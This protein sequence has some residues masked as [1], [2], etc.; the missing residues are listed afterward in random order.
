MV[1]I[2]S[3]PVAAHRSYLSNGATI[4]KKRHRQDHTGRPNS[5][6]RTA[7]ANTPKSKPKLSLKNV[8]QHLGLKDCW[9]RETEKDR[10][11]RAI[12]SLFSTDDLW[13]IVHDSSILKPTNLWI[14]KLYY[15]YSTVELFSNSLW[16]LNNA[17]QASC[18]NWQFPLQCTKLQR[19]TLEGEGEKT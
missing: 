19:C 5:M 9:E 18:N 8:L 13:P 16:L 17:A 6:H 1:S 7:A 11:A 14:V 12:G 4:D 3:V 15:Y 2:N 10:D